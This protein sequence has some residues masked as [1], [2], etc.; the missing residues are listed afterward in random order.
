MHLNQSGRT[1]IGK[2]I[3]MSALRSMKPISDVLEFVKSALELNDHELTEIR[4]NEA[5]GLVGGHMIADADAMLELGSMLL[6]A[7]R[8]PEAEK[9][10]RRA[11]TRNTKSSQLYLLL[12]RILRAAGKSRDA[13]Q[14][15]KEAS[16]LDRTAFLPLIH[17][18]LVQLDLK[19]HS[20]ARAT[21]SRVVEMSPDI[22]EHHRLLAVALRM[23]DDF[24]KAG[25]HF[26]QA[27]KLAPRDPLGWVNLANFRE[28]QN[29]PEE[30][31]PIL[32][33]GI[34]AVGA[35]RR[36]VEARIAALRRRGRY[37]EAAQW[38]GLLLRDNPNVDWLHYQMGMTL[39]QSDRERANIHF[40]RAYGLQPSDTRNLMAFAESLNRTRGPR[41]AEFIDAAYKLAK[42][43][44]DLKGDLRPDARAMINILTRVGDY[45]ATD[46]LGSFEELGEYFVKNGS[47]T[48]L[49]LMLTRARLPEHRAD[50]VEWHQTCCERMIKTAVLSP[51][52][53]S[54]AP[55]IIGRAKIRVGYMSSDLR[56]HP[57]G[58]FVVPIIRH[59]DRSRFEVFAYSWYAR[60]PDET[61]DWIAERIDGF[62][63]ERS[64]SDRDAA[65]LIKND[66]LDVLFDLGG[67][68]DMNKLATLAWRP[69]PRIVSWLGYPH[70]A[71]L[72]TIDRILTD[73]YLEPEDPN[74]LI[75]KPFRLANS[76][77]AYERPG[78]RVEV[79]INPQVP[80]ERNGIVTFGTMNNPLKFN[81]ETIAVWARCM[82]G[83]PGSRFLFVRPE[84]A[85]PSFR[86]NMIAQFE[87]NGIEPNRLA[88][89]AVRG[90]HLPFY[91]EID[92]ALDTFPQTGGT[93]TCETLWMGVPVISL[94]GPG[95]FERLSYS[96]LS[97]AGL[98]HL[99]VRTHDAFVEQA[100]SLAADRTWRTWFRQTI[101]ARLPE[102]NLGNSQQ[103]VSE[104]EGNL[105][106]WVG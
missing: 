70:S 14:V 8:Y 80:E 11:L 61:Q 79:P 33:Q 89:V 16:R 76:W 101:R 7:R 51:L 60:D 29:R 45:A 41:E 85:V 82:L 47:E 98:G 106:D 46:Q 1:K 18:G 91:N 35:H 36:L 21:F 3:P 53:E 83:V 57:V 68:T 24:E 17:Y 5:L 95:M 15:L 92:I 75:E 31:I 102:L 50:L 65:A 42:R 56:N 90:Q 23:A 104:I 54:P 69:A 19:L 64:I 22:S 10:M 32:D 93:T 81:P 88:F 99:A 100:V 73:P 103:F 20:E 59:Y 87:E 26:E 48:A 97:N 55:A 44:L 13:L 25:V 12:G 27:V 34:A 66:R 39:Q 9:L 63:H 58:N 49:H 4:L 37:D 86:G 96:N 71:G 67:S 72:T 84:S 78:L 74:L 105:T 6:N 38:I 52:P 43:R 30:T 40:E 94:I 62:R 77:V 2:V 28:E